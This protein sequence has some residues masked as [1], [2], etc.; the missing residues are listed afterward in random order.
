M[1]RL[2]AA[3]L[4]WVSSIGVAVAGT[5]VTMDGPI[6]DSNAALGVAGANRTYLLNLDDHNVDYLSVQILSSS[7]AYSDATFNDGK[8]ATATWTVAS[9]TALSTA[10]ATGQLTMV[11][12]TVASGVQGTA[13]VVFGTNVGNANILINGPPGGLNYTIG[14]NVAMGGASSAT[15]VNFAAA[16]NLSSNTSL[17]TATQT[18]TNASVVL[19]CVN[20]GTF[21]NNYSVTSS[22][23]AQVSTAAFSGG[24]NP[25]VVSLNGYA[26]KAGADFAVG[27]STAAM[28]ANL[29]AVIMASSMTT[30]VTSTATL[31]CPNNCGVLYATATANGRAGNFQLSS[32]N[33][34]AISTSASTMLGGQDNAVACLNG[35]CVTA[36]KDFYPVTSNAQTATNLAAAFNASVASLT[37]TS[38]AA[39]AVVFST[40][41]IVG[42]AGNYTITTST[43]GALTIGPYT[44]SNVVTGF[45]T[46]TMYGGSSSSYTI[47]TSA[48]RIPSHGYPLALMVSIASTTGN[49]AIYTSTAV[50]GT[51][52]ALTQG[53]TWYVVPIDANN[54]ALAT[55]STM[56]VAGLPVVL[57]SSAVKTTA[58]SWLIHVSTTAGSASFG[59]YGSNNGTDFLQIGSSVT[60]SGGSA[61]VYPSSA[62]YVDIGNVDWKYFQ[63]NVAPPATS[64]AIVIKTW[65]HGE[66]R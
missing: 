35:T 53:S 47:N 25:V 57:V 27:A 31:A 9:Y 48:I 16:V 55:S 40:A 34:L 26:W 45:A 6:T 59:F 29:S 52:T 50:G 44:S 1:K 14:G 3:I 23:P 38:V 28:A 7:G 60:F 37:V 10:A 20:A 18:G 66:K 8:A 58:D 63:M 62:T 43:Q 39:G 4:I 13:G 33:Q 30:G 17:I 22:S 46:G 21:C 5:S 24:T 11:S 42:T 54:I 15:A 12:T 56:A 65:V 41:N 49:T 19:T 64:G 51:A 32:S 36:N 61:Y 2:G